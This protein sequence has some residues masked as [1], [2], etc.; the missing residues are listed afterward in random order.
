MSEGITGVETKMLRFRVVCEIYMPEEETYRRKIW[1]TWGSIPI[2]LFK[3]KSTKWGFHNSIM[4]Q[5]FFKDLLRTSCLISVNYFQ[6][7]I[8]KCSAQ[9]LHFFLTVRVRKYL[10]YNNFFYYKPLEQ[11]TLRVGRYLKEYLIQPLI[12]QIAKIRHR[13][14]E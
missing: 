6:V 11:E 3:Y 10:T 14:D 9:I 7:S 4:C 2:K 5:F 8:F 1:R 13:K 12:L